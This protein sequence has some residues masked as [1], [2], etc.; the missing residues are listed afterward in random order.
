MIPI[1]ARKDSRQQEKRSSLA[2]IAVEYG[3]SDQAHMTRAFR[4]A[5]GL[6]PS[7]LRSLVA[8]S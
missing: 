2:E 1:E 8:G 4:H 3:F 5:C 7:V 6:P